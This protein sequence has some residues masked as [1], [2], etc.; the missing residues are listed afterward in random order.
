MTAD[1]NGSLIHSDSVDVRGSAC[2]A[3]G[4]Q[5]AVPF[6]DGG[7]QPLATLAWPGSAEEARGLKRLPLDFVRCFDCGHIYNSM[8]K[9]EEVP[10]SDKLNLMFNK[11]EVWAE[12]IR[13]IQGDILSRLPDRPTV[14]EI[15]H[16]AGSFLSS[17]AN[18][19]PGG[20][21]VG[22][23]PHGASSES[24]L[25]QLQQKL[26]DPV[27]HLIPIKPDIL[28]SRHVLEH[29][30]N[31]LG[32][33][34]KIS[35]VA[36]SM[37]IRVLAYLEVPCI[38]RVL[39]T[40]RTTDFYY[41]HCSQFTTGSFTRMLESSF[42]SVE[43][44][45]HGYDGEV[46]YGFVSLGEFSPPCLERAREALNFHDASRRGLNRIK[47]QLDE[48]HAS[49]QEIAIWGG[50]GK[51]AAFINRYAVDAE[52]FPIVVDSDAD[53]F[54]TFVPG[55]GQKIHDRDWLR[56]NMIDVVII[57]SQWRARDI[58]NEIHG[59]GIIIGSVLIEHDGM[60][61]DYH[62]DP[63]PYQKGERDCGRI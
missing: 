46:V 57:P 54:G 34:Q 35:C 55:T 52:R 9:Y 61:V 30:A 21:Y 33:L 58:V 25:V 38:D 36:A 28:I 23:D 45:G 19:R 51:G 11:G 6:F 49:G 20:R 27:R 40:G 26:F 32:F 62:R 15:G 13:M 2:P 37:R 60:L 31:P 44:I 12:F 5:V 59:L 41:E 47:G 39:E 63:H 22:F 42:S 50:T 7:A 3:C 1:N 16:G 18:N 53:K 48:L 10:Y 56:S 24:N 29:M 4:C 14:V 17:L 43:D 8:F